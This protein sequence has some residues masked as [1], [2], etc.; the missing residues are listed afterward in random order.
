MAV[1]ALDPVELATP[2]GAPLLGP[3]ELSPAE[4]S[5]AELSPATISSPGAPGR[6]RSTT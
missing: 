5:P 4:L 2:S 1:L 3:A 6:S